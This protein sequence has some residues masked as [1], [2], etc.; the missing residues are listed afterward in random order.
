MLWKATDANAPFWTISFILTSTFLVSLT[1]ATPINN[2]SPWSTIQNAD[3]SNSQGRETLFRS[4][5]AQSRKDN[6]THFDKRA[7]RLEDG[8]YAWAI[9]ADPAT[10]AFGPYLNNHEFQEGTVVLEENIGRGANGVVTQAT[11]LYADTEGKPVAAKLALEESAWNGATLVQEIGENPHLPIIYE[12]LRVPELSSSLVLMNK[13]GKS[14]EDWWIELGHENLLGTIDWQEGI[15]QA[16]EVMVE[17]HEKMIVHLDFKLENMLAPLEPRS[18]LTSGSTLISSSWTWTVI[19]WDQGISLGDY[20]KTGQAI[21]P[22]IRTDPLYATPGQFKLALFL[23]YI[24]LQEAHT[25]RL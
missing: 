18:S 24:C 23:L 14:A 12:K 19:D 25:F 17:A 4:L 20:E 22:D 10:F 15:Q 2:V 13:L 8:K 5:Q 6:D 7:T 21:F 16:T 11:L 9:S 1:S 3:S